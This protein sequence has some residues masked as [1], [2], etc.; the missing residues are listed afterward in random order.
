MITVLICAATLLEADCN[1]NN[2][3][4]VIKLPHE[5][6]VLCG[7]DVQETEAITGLVS[8]GVYL[9]IICRP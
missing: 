4:S 5:P 2:A 6:G 3:Y 7:L 1:V 9:K 8:D